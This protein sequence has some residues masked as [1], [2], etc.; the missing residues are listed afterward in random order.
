[1]TS[2]EEQIRKLLEG[3]MRVKML[4]AVLH[5]EMSAILQ[6][7][8]ALKAAGKSQADINAA[9]A[10]ATP[11]IAALNQQLKAAHQDIGVSAR[12]M[13]D[14]VLYSSN[15]LQD[16]AA[17]G[18]R[19]VTNNIPQI[20]QA[21][22]MGSGLAGV[23]MAV[24][25]AFEASLPF[26]Q[27]FMEGLSPDRVGAF[28]SAA[29]KA[30]ARIE[31]LKKVASPSAADDLER[32][33]LE[34]GVR[35]REA[36][37]R[38]GEGEAERIGHP[39]PEIGKAVARVLSES[40][41]SSDTFKK[42]ETASTKSMGDEAADKYERDLRAQLE[43]DLEYTR[44]NAASAWTDTGEL[45][46]RFKQALPK[47]RKAARLKAEEDARANLGALLAK[48]KAGDPAA[49]AELSARL[50]ES[51]NESLAAQL[52]D[53]AD[54][55]RIE[56]AGPMG[57]PD[58]LKDVRD[59]EERRRKAAGPTTV[60]DML[61]EVRDDQERRESEEWENETANLEHGHALWREKKAARAE[62]D[63]KR[64]AAF[65]R[66]R[67]DLNPET[68]AEALMRSV[69]MGVDDTEWRGHMTG[70]QRM[71]ANAGLRRGSRWRYGFGGDYRTV[72]R[73]VSLEEASKQLE[74]QRYEALVGQGVDRSTAREQAKAYGER[75]YGAQMQTGYNAMK[76]LQEMGMTGQIG[77]GVQVMGS[78]QYIG[79]VQTAREGIDKQMLD[80]QKKIAEAAVYQKEWMRVNGV[81][82]RVGRRK[83]P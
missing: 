15:A 28:V 61:K 20:L 51:G 8:H 57:P 74:E 16:F 42:M 34:R 32:K 24:G 1:M 65:E 43:R 68:D 47:G 33:N 50:R 79:S 5:Q 35:E 9:W 39:G 18:M 76:Q 22:G 31:E 25:V 36:G 67:P 55:A 3:E 60:P 27:K 77:R 21:L 80:L 78:E 81:A 62:K 41:S 11:K 52:E 26:I 72:H 19:G 4:T 10:Q 44:N 48:A 69:A 49:I 66:G 30:I 6:L 58:T 71:Q 56:A 54:R 64:I 70:A 14:A 73:A 63:R 45:K 53:A 46:R 13:G 7:D 12:R 83:G 75:A 37:L 40:A 23:A 17:A 82:A 38:T 29:D 59:D 2:E